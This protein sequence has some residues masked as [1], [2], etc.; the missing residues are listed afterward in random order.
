M[1]STFSG[2]FF[3]GPHLNVCDTLLRQSCP[4]PWLKRFV[5]G[6]TVQNIL[7]LQ[8]ILLLYWGTFIVTCIV[9]WKKHTKETHT[10]TLGYRGPRAT[11][12]PA[13]HSDTW[14]PFKAAVEPPTS[15]TS[16]PLQTRSQRLTPPRRH[17]DKG[18]RPVTLFP[19]WQNQSVT[20]CQ[21]HCYKRQPV[22]AFMCHTVIV[23][24]A[25]VQFSSTIVRPW[26]H[27]QTSSSNTVWDILMFSIC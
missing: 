3:Q 10:R 23:H 8:Y 25:Q 15:T 20:H 19:M 17:R 11:C 4:K 1:S 22:E 16:F 27:V 13:W 7:Y 2:V 21:K 5:R 12:L 14:D 24:G 6:F 18:L 9:T 26:S